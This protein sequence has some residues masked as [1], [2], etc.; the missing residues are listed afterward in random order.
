[1]RRIYQTAG[2][3][4]APSGTEDKGT[5]TQYLR[6]SWSRTS[7]SIDLINSPLSRARK[8]CSRLSVSGLDEARKIAGDVLGRRAL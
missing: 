5:M 6:D 7:F 2:S 8:A 3:T 1:M 4:V